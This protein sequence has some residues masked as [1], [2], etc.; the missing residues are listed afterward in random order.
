MKIL[1]NSKTRL[2]FHVSYK[3]KRA[4][5][6]LR[7]RFLLVH[8]VSFPYYLQLV[9][10]NGAPRMKL[11]QDIAKV[12]IP[13]KKNIYRLYGNDGKIRTYIASL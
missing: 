1:R 13:G 9:E 6:K 5:L 11:S 3:K 12:T 8:F 7:I 2:K 4:V 10:L